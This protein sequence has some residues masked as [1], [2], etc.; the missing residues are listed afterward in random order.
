MPSKILESYLFGFEDS[1][2]NYDSVILNVTPLELDL[3]LQAYSSVLN[4]KVKLSV[5]NP[6]NADQNVAD[7]TLIFAIQ[8]DIEINNGEDAIVARITNFSAAVDSYTAYFNCHSNFKAIK[9]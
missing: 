6:L 7:L 1:F 9:S 2:G 3:D 5:V 8:L 4:C